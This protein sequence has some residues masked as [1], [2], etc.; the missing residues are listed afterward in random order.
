MNEIR[1][2]LGI[3]LGGTNI[4]VGLVQND[5]ITK[6]ITGPTP[7][8][9]TQDEVIKAITEKI[10]AFGLDIDAI[11]I[12]VPGIVDVKKGIVY[13]VANIPQWK[14][15]H[16]KEILEEKYKIPA[17]VNNDANCFAAGEKFFGKGLGYE[18]FVGLVLGTGLGGGIILN[19][20]LYEGKNCGAG[21][22]GG[23]PYL[24]NNYEYYCSGKFFK[25]I[26]Q[27]TALEASCNAENGAKEALTMFNELGIHIGKMIQMVLYSYDPEIILLGGSVSKSFKLFKDSMMAT[28]NEFPFKQTLKSL[29][30]EVSELENGAIFG[31]ASL[32]YN[33]LNKSLNQSIKINT[34]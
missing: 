24:D 2:V 7:A 6:I 33:N 3:D 27:V 22:F 19:D 21:E 31:A 29:K 10:D 26:Y 5:K 15:V 11:G 8:T 12:G 17:F 13:D 16:L 18:S 4:R 14:Q 34:I 30:I 23:I 20:K 9:G 28:V 1:N 25:N 32:Y